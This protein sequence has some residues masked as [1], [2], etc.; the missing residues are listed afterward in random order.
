MEQQKQLT[1]EAFSVGGVLGTGAFG[2]VF[3]V[4]KRSTGSIFAMKV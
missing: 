2:A 1:L 3:K 4:Q